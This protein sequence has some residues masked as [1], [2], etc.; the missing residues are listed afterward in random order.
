MVPMSRQEFEEVVADALDQIPPRLTDLIDNVVILVEDDPPPQ[1][2]NLLGI[3]EG[4][5]LPERGGSWGYG[6]LPDRIMI[7]R[8]PTLRVCYT[9]EQVVKEVLITVV[10]EIAH[11]FGISEG[12]LIELGWG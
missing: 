3:Y 10:H 7:F 11:Y 8:N 5:P 6:N 12:R 9:R 4:I 2:P 1:T